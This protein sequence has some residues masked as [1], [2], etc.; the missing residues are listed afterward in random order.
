MNNNPFAKLP[1]VAAF[2]VTSNDIVE[3]FP[4]PPQQYAS[5]EEGAKIFRPI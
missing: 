2:Q 1:E 5:G 4:L 3:G